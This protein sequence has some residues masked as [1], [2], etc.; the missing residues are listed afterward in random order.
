MRPLKVKSKLMTNKTEFMMEDGEF[1]V[2]KVKNET[3][4]KQMKQMK[5]QVL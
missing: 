4:D 1:E 3:K 5:T 2:Y